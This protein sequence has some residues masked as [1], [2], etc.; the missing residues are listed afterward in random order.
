MTGKPRYQTIYGRGMRVLLNHAH[1]VRWLTGDACD[2]DQMGV[3]RQTEDDPGEPLTWW[4]CARWAREQ[5]I[6]LCSMVS[7]TPKHILAW[8]L[9]FR[10]GYALGME[11]VIRVTACYGNPVQVEWPC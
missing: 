9:Q 6:S 5:G 3:C 10:S 2:V 11:V 8:S 1:A 4:L 7:C